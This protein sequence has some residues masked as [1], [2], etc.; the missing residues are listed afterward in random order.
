[1]VPLTVS[2]E[3]VYRA[4]CVYAVDGIILTSSDIEVAIKV[5]SDIGDPV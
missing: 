1:M 5:G 4:G 3:V 2:G